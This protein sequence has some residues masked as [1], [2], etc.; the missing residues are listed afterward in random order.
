MLL[1]TNVILFHNELGLSKTIDVFAEAGF[2]GI[3]FNTDLA[4]HYD[5]TH[6]EDF[7]RQIG[8]YAKEKGVPITQAH[9]PFPSSYADDEARTAKRF[10]EIVIGMRNAALLGAEVIVVHPCKHI[11][12]VEDPTQLEYMKAYNLD[13]YKRLSPL[14]KELGIKIAIENILGS[15]TVSPEGLLRLLNELNDESFTVCYDVGHAHLSGQGASE[16]LY[17]LGGV[18]GCTHIHDNNGAS[19]GHTLPYYGTIDWEAVTKAFAEVGYEGNLNYEAG[20]FV[21]RAPVALRLESATYMAKI[22][23]YLKERVQ[24]YKDSIVK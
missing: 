21:K 7:Y 17:A 15:V 22:G 13:F 3:E 14:A 5:N 4:E 10:D 2:E 11:D 6:G 1:T 18:I 16:M 24:Y 23:R 20:I 8:A 9:A 19:D 12:C